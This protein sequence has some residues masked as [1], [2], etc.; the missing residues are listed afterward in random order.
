ML[1]KFQSLESV[2][3]RLLLQI[4]IAL[5]LISLGLSAFGFRRIHAVLNRLA[6]SGKASDD[7][8]TYI[9]RTKQWIRFTKHCGPFRGNC[10][11]RSL[12]LWWLLRRRGIKA[13]LRI[14][15]RKYSGQFQAH[16]WV[17]HL[18]QA[19]NAGPAVRQHYAAF[20]HVFTPDGV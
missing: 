15:S 12:A 2:D 4:T 7:P 18:G 16:A 9:H 20:N 11:S 19:V 14:G 13:D 5:P 10:L 3:Y 6:N 1:R 8:A 17:E